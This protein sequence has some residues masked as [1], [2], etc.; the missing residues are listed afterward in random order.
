MVRAVREDKAEIIITERPIRPLIALAAV[1]PNAAI[2]ARTSKVGTRAA[3]RG[4]RR[5]RRP[6]LAR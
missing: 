1:A 2:M 6:E 3:A 4:V 5:R